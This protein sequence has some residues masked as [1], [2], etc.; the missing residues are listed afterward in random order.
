D[1]LLGI[2]GT[3]LDGPEDLAK[4]LSS[5]NQD[6][7]AAPTAPE[8]AVPVQVWRAG[9]T[10]DLTV[11]ARAWKDVRVSPRP[12]AEGVAA[13]RQADARLREAQGPS[14]APL[15]GTRREVAAIAQLF[16][17]AD[18]LLG[19]EA[20]EQRLEAFVAA[21]RLRDY[22]YLHLATHAVL[23]L[24]R[25]LQ[26]ALILAR[27]R[28]PDPLT[29]VLAGRGSYDGRLTAEHIRRTWQLDA[30]L[31]TLS[32]CQTGLGRYQGGE[33]YLGFSQALFLVGARGLVLSLWKVDDQ[34]TAL[35]M[36]RFYQNLLGR[37]AGLEG[38]LPKAEALR[39]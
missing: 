38:P 11:P 27:D 15:P 2:A 29:Q 9:R 23:D 25:P 30:D 35:L 14:F 18:R 10:L 31:V 32:A 7:G 20:S 3:K 26:S 4:A 21:G 5:P 6:R 39:E 13:R 33:G 22:R 17:Q 34:V 28:L 19:S 1:V 37:R 24:E 8:A 16:P 12:A 36:R